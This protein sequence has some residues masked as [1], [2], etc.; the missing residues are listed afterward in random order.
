MQGPKRQNKVSGW[1]G[2]GFADHHLPRS[3]ISNG[4]SVC[5]I[6]VAQLPYCKHYRLSSRLFSAPAKEEEEEGLFEQ[7]N[8]FIISS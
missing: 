3:L 7:T 8:D 5:G 4:V 6:I 2:R 1:E